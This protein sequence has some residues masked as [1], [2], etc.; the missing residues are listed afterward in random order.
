MA[1]IIRTVAAALRQ[2][3]SAVACVGFCY[4]AKGTV[5]AMKSGD[6]TTIVCFH[7]S[8]LEAADAPALK[9][10][11]KSLWQIPETDNRFDPIR[12]IF[13]K[14]LSGEEGVKFN[15]YMGCTHG[16]GSRP[17]GENELAG[18]TQAHL[19]VIEWLGANF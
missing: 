17:H 1:P 5:D 6:I 19:D 15:T 7:P 8:R 18:K 2:K 16:F 9:G 12:A 10:K 14:E 3:Y 4:G 13:E 11:G